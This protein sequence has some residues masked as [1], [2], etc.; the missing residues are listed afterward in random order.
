[1]LSFR[2]RLFAGTATWKETADNTVTC[3]QLDGGE[4]AYGIV[5]EIGIPGEVG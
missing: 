2:L 5:K 4:V 3:G 1:V